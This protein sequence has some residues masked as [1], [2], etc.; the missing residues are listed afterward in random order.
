MSEETEYLCETCFL[1]S[2]ETGACTLD[3]ANCVDGSE[4]LP[5]LAPEDM[6]KFFYM[7]LYSTNGE[8]SVPV[9]ALEKVTE[10][11]KL[12]PSYD[13]KHKRWVIKTSIQPEAVPRKARRRG[14]IKIVK[15]A[16]SQRALIAA[17]NVLRN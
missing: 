11:M 15:P 14:K 1:A 4:Y 12:I 5:E 17:G 10:D 6:F 2:D 8:M 9:E 7:L 3:D 16:M 13:R